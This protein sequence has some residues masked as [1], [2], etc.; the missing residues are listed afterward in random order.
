[1]ARVGSVLSEAEAGAPAGVPALSGVAGGAE[2]EDVRNRSSPLEEPL[3]LEL[4]GWSQTDSP[5]PVAR[6]PLHREIPWDVMM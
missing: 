5:T 1:M 3:A 4:V 6:P 2:A